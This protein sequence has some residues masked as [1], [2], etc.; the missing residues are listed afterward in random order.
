MRQRFF[1]I[2]LLIAIAAVTTAMVP[3]S[4]AIILRNRADAGGRRIVSHTRRQLAAAGQRIVRRIR[5]AT[6]S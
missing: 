6:A 4:I 1:L 5:E 3:F 2:A